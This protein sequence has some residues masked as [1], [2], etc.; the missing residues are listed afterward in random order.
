MNTR[1]NPNVGK[2]EEPIG[3]QAKD[4][5]LR[6]ACNKIIHVKE[7]KYEII[8]GNYEWNRYLKPTIYLYG[9]RQENRWRATIDIIDFCF[10]VCHAPE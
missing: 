3:S 2:L 4:L 10:E 7:I 8:D 9:K 5:T 1:W 6:E